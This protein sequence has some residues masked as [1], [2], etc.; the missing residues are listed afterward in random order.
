MPGKPRRKPYEQTFGDIFP[1]PQPEGPRDD[2]ER[3]RFLFAVV[4]ALLARLDRH[5]QLEAIE[6]AIMFA[7]KRFGTWAKQ[8]GLTRAA[9][10]TLEIVSRRLLR[11]IKK[12]NR[13]NRSQL[14]KEL[15][16]IRAHIRQLTAGGADLRKW[17][18]DQKFKSNQ[19]DSVVRY[20][21]LHRSP[22]LLLEKILAERHEI[23]TSY[24]H[25]I[26]AP[27]F[28]PRT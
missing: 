2:R 5:R 13:P 23:S 8:N 17:L 14:H 3:I 25:K 18:T 10:M 1:P 28:K 11:D 7:E 6:D 9:Q 4:E 20:W 24:V 12:E 21:E 27:N 22:G 16:E 26:L 19:I 15:T